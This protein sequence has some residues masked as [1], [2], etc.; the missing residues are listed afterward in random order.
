MADDTYEL[1]YIEKLWSLIPGM[2]RD[3]DG[4][5]AT[6]G[7]PGGRHQLRAMVEVLGAQAAVLRRSADRTWDDQ[8]IDACDDWAVAYLG[9]LV[10]TRMLPA[11]DTRAR[12]VDVAKTVYYRRRKGTL[13]VLEELISDIT[14]WEGVAAE[15]FRRLGR[16]WNRLDQLP[17]QR[18]GTF[19][20]TM[21]GGTADLRSL[22]GAELA[23]G[24]FSE[25]AY[26][27]DV[28]PHRGVH[29]WR[30]IPKVSF[31]LYRLASVPVL[32]MRPRSASASPGSYHFDQLRRDVPLFARAGRQQQWD[33]WR[34]LQPW[35]VPAP[36]SCRLLNHAVYDVTPA[37]IATAIFELPGLSQQERDDLE[38]LRGRRYESTGALHDAIGEIDSGG[39]LDTP[40]VH[41]AVEAASI[42][43]D[44]GK[45][46]LLGTSIA[47]TDSTGL[48]P[49]EQIIAGDLSTWRTPPPGYRAIID[50]TLGRIRFDQPQTRSPRADIHIGV[51]GAVGAN[52]LPRGDL[53]DVTQPV[54]GGG[55]LPVLTDGGV[56]EVDNSLAYRTPVADVAIQ[57][58]VVQSADGERPFVDMNADWVFTSLAPNAELTL[59][60]LWLGGGNALVIRGDFA[61]VT[62][63]RCTLDGSSVAGDGTTLRVEGNIGRLTIERS[64]MSRIDVQP[65]AVVPT[66]TILDSVVDGDDPDPLVGIAIAADRS[67]LDLRGVT[68][69]GQTAALRLWADDVLAVGDVRVADTQVG[70]FRFSSAP[71]GS[72]LTHP[73]ESTT[74][75]PGSSF[76]TRDQGMPAYAQLREGLTVEVARG[77]E[78]GSEM[79]AFAHLQ[80][81]ISFDSLR[82]KVEEYLP[83]GLVPIYVFAN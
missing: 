80:Q 71:A 27:A 66:I 77:A 6:A 62:L 7:D 53:A 21:P 61:S 3:L 45:A 38:S 73:Y 82:T 32:T 9:D 50:P 65:T 57:S 25:F 8:F 68:V 22:M 41:Q 70:C 16:A 18:R 54:S 13:R 31:H 15:Q 75:P 1:H 52:P 37:A 30:G 48:I 11:L 63:R 46:A 40:Q 81:P 51:V 76:T 69:I 74:T 34:S 58:L 72:R 60:G 78:D 64:L 43:D 35:E 23:S 36:I 29:G 33:D 49:P 12:R 24:P 14:G 4:R 19:T 59:D 39:T 47:I 79:G 20:A 2:H 42:I 17:G 55:V 67:T 5:D 26:S 56:A 83:F 28:R 10:A 44:C